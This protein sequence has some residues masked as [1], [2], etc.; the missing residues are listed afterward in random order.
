MAGAAAESAWVLCLAI[1]VACGGAPDPDAGVVEES[2]ERTSQEI[3]WG[4]EGKNGPAYWA[5]LSLD[6]ARCGEGTEQSPIDLAG[7]DMVEGAPLESARGEGLLTVAQRARVMD[8]V[9]NG[10]TIQVTSD[11]FVALD[12]DGEHYELV[13]YHFHAPSEH[14]VDGE[15]APL[16]VH[17]VLKSPAGNMAVAAWLVDV[18]DRDPV[19]DH[20]VAALPS[21]PDD[22]RHLEVDLELRELPPTSDLYYRYRGSLTTP[23]CSEDVEWIVAAYRHR[24]SPEQM[25]AITSRLHQNNRPVQP[26]GERELLLIS[27]R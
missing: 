20:L 26:V 19:W 3:H 6:F 12:L 13:Q 10:H 8:L 25:A 4:Y 17:F 1:F 21:G 15:H 22:S 18:G 24:I 27:S 7:A 5:E 16:E 14:T 11:A 9:D 23:P 2:A